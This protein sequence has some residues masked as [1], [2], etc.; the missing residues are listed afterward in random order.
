MNSQ[1]DISWNIL[2][3][4]PGITRDASNPAKPL[5]GAFADLPR[6]L[7]SQ[8]DTVG[9]CRPH[10]VCCRMLPCCL[11][12]LE[13]AHAFTSRNCGN[14]VIYMVYTSLYVSWVQEYTN[15]ATTILKVNSYVICVAMCRHVLLLSQSLKSP[16]KSS[17]KA[18]I[19]TFR[20]NLVCK[21]ATQGVAV[22]DTKDKRCLTFDLV[23]TPSIHALWSPKFPIC[24][25]NHACDPS[26]ILSFQLRTDGLKASSSGKQ[27]TCNCRPNVSNSF[28]LFSCDWCGMRSSTL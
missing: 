24:R 28:D 4:I 25:P 9:F 7:N 12:C 15:H 21:D 1:C 23:Q 17:C 10:T 18:G 13:R 27:R 22:Q 26:W 20:Q 11:C 16:A 2:N 5:S 3:V 6:N 8:V 14:F 19:Q